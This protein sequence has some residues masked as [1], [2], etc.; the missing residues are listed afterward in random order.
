MKKAITATSSA[1]Q[2]TQLLTHT[3]TLHEQT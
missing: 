3:C 2:M 1:T